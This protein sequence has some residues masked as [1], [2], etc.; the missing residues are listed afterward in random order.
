LDL[1]LGLDLDFEVH[2]K[3]GMNKLQIGENSVAVGAR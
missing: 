1:G 2:D 3:F